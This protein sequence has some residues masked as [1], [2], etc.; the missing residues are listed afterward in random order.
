MYICF[1]ILN[2]VFPKDSYDQLISWSSKLI[3]LNSH[4]ENIQDATIIAMWL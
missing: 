1:N 2:A 3:L 4:V